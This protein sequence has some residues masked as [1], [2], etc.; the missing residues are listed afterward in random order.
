MTVTVV[1]QSQAI[2]LAKLDWI[3]YGVRNLLIKAL[4]SGKPIANRN[5]PNPGSLNNQVMVYMSL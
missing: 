4:M 5:L 3:V 2:L 1:H